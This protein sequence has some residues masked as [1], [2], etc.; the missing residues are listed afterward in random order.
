MTSFIQTRWEINK[1]LEVVGSIPKKKFVNN[2][3][4]LLS[5]LQLCSNTFNENLWDKNFE[6][7][8]NPS[9]CKAFALS[10]HDN[11]FLFW[12][13]INSNEQISNF[14]DKEICFQFVC[15]DS[16]IVI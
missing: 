16:V 9:V 2:S 15:V 5:N 12:V 11:T 7:V 6:L 4:L 3:E 14:F 13:S 8:L 1:L 10:K